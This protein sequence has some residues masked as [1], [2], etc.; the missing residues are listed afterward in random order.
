MAISKTEGLYLITAGRLNM[1]SKGIDFPGLSPQLP[2]QISSEKQSVTAIKPV[3]KADGGRLR[4][5]L[6][7]DKAPVSYSDVS[8]DHTD[9]E[10]AKLAAELLAEEVG[11]SSKFEVTW[12]VNEDTGTLFVEIKDK[13]TGEVLRQIPPNDI[14]A[15][16]NQSADLS[17]LLLNKTV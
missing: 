4:S 3:E 11:D 9:E 10:S 17:G 8:G 5:V 12:A 15:N 1:D 13:N 6:E 2:L 14:L 16:A 7:G